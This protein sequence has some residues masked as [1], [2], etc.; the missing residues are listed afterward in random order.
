[1]CDLKGLLRIRIQTLSLPRTLL[2]LRHRQD[3]DGSEDT[4]TNPAS[5]RLKSLSSV[6]N[7]CESLDTHARTHTEKE[8]ASIL[9]AWRK[10]E[11]V[12]YRLRASK[13]PM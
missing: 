11:K 3:R 1:M 12:F 8:R 9:I 10:T 6:V 13:H 4:A 2:T 7:K 5:I